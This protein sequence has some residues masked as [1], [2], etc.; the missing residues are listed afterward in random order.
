MSEAAGRRIV[1][2][3]VARGV[4]LIGMAAYHFTWDLA[5]F[6]L[7]APE[8]PFAPPMRLLSHSVA[9]AFLGLAGV[10]LALAHAG[11]PRWPA[12]WR[13][14]GMIAAAAALVSAATYAMDSNTTIWFGILHCIAAASL[15]AALFLRAPAALAVLVGLGLVIVPQ[16][17]RS[18]LFNPPALLWLGLGATLPDTL[19]WR[20]LLPWAGVLLISFGLAKAS[21]PW[22]TGSAFAR[23]RGAAALAFAGRHSLAIYL[24][25]Q[26]LL[27]GLLFV[28]VQTTG[29][30]EQQTK[31][32]YVA[33]CR[34]ACVEMG[35]E[36][37]AC[38]RACQCVADR[39][40][41]AGLLKA[42][43]QRAP[44]EATRKRVVEIVQ[45]CGTGAL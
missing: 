22:L 7:V 24:I 20:P 35:G 25:H 17:W 18:D 13:R 14:F 41:N 31:T 37:E 8:T 9:S 4:A 39:V 43:A 40:S 30:A 45:A 2:I 42:L 34:P 3:D 29:I 15:L 28:L 1:A 11:A 27:F 26:P 44:D 33:A 21:R 10:S 6:G 23:W 36:L 5:N 38:R 12:Y 19:D 32:N 16:L